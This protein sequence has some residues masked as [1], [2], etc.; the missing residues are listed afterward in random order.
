MY[1]A[2]RLQCALLSLVLA[3]CSTYDLAHGSHSG[4]VVRV[5]SPAELRK[6]HPHCSENLSD[7]DINDR[8]YAEIMIRHGRTARYVLAAIPN[9]LKPL[10]HDE[11]EISPSRCTAGVVPEIKQILNARHK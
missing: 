3:G 9:A 4:Y 6:E 5:Y 11:V 2:L 1:P 7:K 8:K 10:E